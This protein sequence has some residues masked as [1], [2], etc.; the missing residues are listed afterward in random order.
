[1][2]IGR[3][4]CRLQLHWTNLWLIRL[5]VALKNYIANMFH[6]SPRYFSKSVTNHFIFSL[7]SG[8]TRLLKFILYSY[9]SQI[10]LKKSIDSLKTTVS[11]SKLK[12]QLPAELNLLKLCIWD[13]RRILVMVN[14]VSKKAINLKLSVLSS[15]YSLLLLIDRIL[16]YQYQ[17][18]ITF[19][20]LAPIVI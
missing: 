5:W 19:I 12:L 11:H 16:L 1:M 14:V 4:L 10:S 7:C 8:T 13:F 17:Q 15:Y 2:F 6:C 18:F 3:H 20:F 9:C